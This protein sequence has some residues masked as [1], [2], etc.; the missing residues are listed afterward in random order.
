M[1]LSLILLDSARKSFELL[2]NG[3]LTLAKI[4]AWKTLLLKVK[5]PFFSNLEDLRALCPVESVRV[6]LTTIQF[7]LVI[8]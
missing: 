6:K 7:Y 2:K 4:I 1:S 3:L 8:F 5:R